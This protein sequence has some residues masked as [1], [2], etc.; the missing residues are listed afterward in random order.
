M[1]LRQPSLSV[2]L[3]LEVIDRDCRISFY[4]SQTLGFLRGEDEELNN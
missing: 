4:V 2:G 3:H 1:I